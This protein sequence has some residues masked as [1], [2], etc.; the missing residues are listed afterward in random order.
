MA[1]VV[2]VGTL[3]LAGAGIAAAAPVPATQAAERSSVQAPLAVPAEW[4]FYDAYP[5]INEC[6]DEGN[7][8]Y[9]YLGYPYDCR[10]DVEGGWILY[11]WY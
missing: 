3:S 6:I 11:L 9:K 5:N 1:T 4:N 2:A 10:P 7:W 8:F